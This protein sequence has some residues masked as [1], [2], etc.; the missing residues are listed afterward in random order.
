MIGLIV[1]EVFPAENESVDIRKMKTIH[2]KTGSQYL[3]IVCIFNYS[4]SAR[5]CG[6]INDKI[7]LASFFE[8]LMK[9]KS[10]TKEQL[11]NESS[12]LRKKIAT[13]EEDISN[14]RKSGT[15]QA[16][17]ASIIKFSEDAIIGKTLDGIITSWNPAAEKIFGYTAQEAIGN[18]LQILMPPDRKDEEIGIIARIGRGEIIDHFETV[19]VRKDGSPIDVSVMIAPI[20]DSAGKVIGASKIARDITERKRA[21]TELEK[22]R[23]QLQKALDEVRTLRGIIPICSYCKEIRDDKGYWN[24]L[25]KYISEHSEAQFSHGICDK[26]MKKLYPQFIDS[27]GKGDKEPEQ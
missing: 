3:K 19:R 13:L 15:L 1:E 18:P 11:I 23:L 25:E 20:K 5:I 7:E 12:E 17:F 10:R 4:Q 14:L 27:S 16:E 22:K 21:E 26:C 9:D 2:N 8:I 24:K 6:I